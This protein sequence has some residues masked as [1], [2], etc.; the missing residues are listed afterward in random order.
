MKVWGRQVIQE[1][2]GVGA[3][4]RP[5]ECEEGALQGQLAGPLYPAFTS[6]AEN[7]EVILSGKG[8][9]TVEIL[10]AGKCAPRKDEVQHIST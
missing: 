9:V 2:A 5:R 8:M 6:W 4:G 3:T 1:D 10:E 7:T